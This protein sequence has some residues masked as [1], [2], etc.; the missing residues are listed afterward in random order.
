M[1]TKMSLFKSVRVLFKIEPAPKVIWNQ[2]SSKRKRSHT[3]FSNNVACFTLVS[4]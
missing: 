2:Q 3:I 1:F 4:S